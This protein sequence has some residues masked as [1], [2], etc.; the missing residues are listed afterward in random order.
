MVFDAAA[1]FRDPEGQRLEY[2]V[3]N[4]DTTVV[5]ASIG[6][7]RVNGR[8]EVSL[9]ARAV[10]EALVTVEATDP[11]DLSARANFA[12]AV[13]PH[14]DQNARTAERAAL[15]A[16]YEAAGGP[17]W[18]DNTNWL[19]DAPVWEWAGV[20]AS[21]ALPDGAGGRVTGLNLYSNNLNGSIPPELGTL[22]RL[23][24]VYL[25]RNALTGPIPPELGNLASVDRLW[26]DRNAL[27]GAIPPELGNLANLRVVVNASPAGSGSKL[28]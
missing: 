9:S 16:M 26:L 19:T 5:V 4:S 27:T 28:S 7:S 3:A 1:H 2:T 25:A 23:R 20:G 14:A 12:A 21:E 11:G 22:A 15:M 8:V 24:M 18:T 10:G 13:T 6:G 17:E